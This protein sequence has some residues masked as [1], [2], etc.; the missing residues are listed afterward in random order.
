MADSKQTGIAVGGGG[1]AGAGL[2]GIVGFMTHDW[3]L[4]GILV[5][6]IIVVILFIGGI[7]HLLS[8]LEKKKK[9]AQMEG[10]TSGGAEPHTSDANERA[11]LAKLRLQWDEGLDK[12][13]KAGIDIYSKPWVLI[14]GPSGAGKTEAIRHAELLLKDKKL[15]DPLAGVGGTLNMNWWFSN[16]SV[17]L[18]TAGRMFLET[19][20]PGK[21]SE[22]IEFLKL[23]KRARPKAPINGVLLVI[24]AASLL[25]ETDSQITTT[26]EQIAER[27]E[28]IKG[29]LNVRFPVYVMITKSDLLT[30]PTCSARFSAGPTPRSMRP[31]IRK[32]STITSKSSATASSSAAPACWRK[33]SPSSPAKAPSWMKS[34]NSTPSPTPSLK[35]PRASASTC[36]TS[37]PAPAGMKTAAPSSAA[38]SSPPP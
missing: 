17:F 36:R 6:G 9:A 15:Q 28:D 30:T 27:L 34:T 32:S 20:T 18:D 5:A 33:K 37:S 35:S 8:R 38:S 25:V 3:M 7:L 4:V 24:S 1:V 13:K 11:T 23:V 26:S 14:V 2:L 31:S 19:V 16:D 12:L 10:A 21:T 29:T 22:W